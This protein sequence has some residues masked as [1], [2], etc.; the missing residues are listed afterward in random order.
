M[1]RRVSTALERIYFNPAHEASFG[2]VE[3]LYLA[4]KSKGITRQQVVDWL[5]GKETY[6]LHKRVSRKFKR[7]KVMVSNI[8]EQ[9]QADLNDMRSLSQYNDGYNY[10][11]T[12]IDCF[13]RK[14]WGVAM[15]TKSG[16]EMVK[17]FKTVF[18]EKI[19]EKLNG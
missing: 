14:A 3:K 11:L 16:L 5:K 10:I 18:K 17:A 7:N 2:G 8:G 12:V 1:E 15:K 19:P 9:Y 4:S 6:T 13:S